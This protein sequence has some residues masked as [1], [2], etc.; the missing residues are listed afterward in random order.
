M[1]NADLANKVSGFEEPLVVTNPYTPT[2]DA[3]LRVNFSPSS[4]SIDATVYVLQDGTG[5]FYGMSTRGSNLMQYFPA[6]AGKEYQ[7][8]ASHPGTIGLALIP[9]SFV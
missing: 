9:F 4:G 7:A 8:F 5:W 6:F 1:K 2:E 3:I